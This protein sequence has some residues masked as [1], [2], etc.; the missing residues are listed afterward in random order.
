MPAEDGPLALEDAP[1]MTSRLE[2]KNVAKSFGEVHAL[3]GVDLSIQPGEIR[4]LLGHNGSGKSTLIKILAGLHRPDRHDA[5]FIDGQTFDL[6]SSSHA[7]DFGLRFVHQELGVVLDLSA[8]DNLALVTGYARSR[9]G[10]IAWR[11][12]RQ[13]TLQQL[14]RVGVSL[15]VDIPLSSA[16]RVERTAVALARALAGLET[17]QGML[18]LDEP[19][20]A[21]PPTEVRYLFEVIHEVRKSGTSVLYVSHRIDEVLAIADRVTVLR[22]GAV[23]AEDDVSRCSHRDLVKI[24]AEGQDH[25][26]Q[27]AREKTEVPPTTATQFQPGRRGLSVR[28]L[29]GRYLR[30]VALDVRPGEIVGVAG[31]VGSGR[32]E[33]PYAVVGARRERISG[34]VAIDGR[35]MDPPRI[36]EARD[37]GIAFVPADKFREG[38]IPQ[39]NVRENLT[40]SCLDQASRWGCLSRRQEAVLAQRLFS[41]IGVRGT[42]GDATI[43]SLSGGNQQKVLIVRAL[44]QHPR[45]LVL[46]E[47]TAGVDVGALGT[48]FTLLRDSAG[49][50]M[51]ILIAESDPYALVELCERVLVLRDGRVVEELAGEHLTVQG[52]VSA[53]E[54]MSLVATDG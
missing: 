4:A 17:G 11:R 26:Q 35:T 50:G 40:L 16:T 32:D 6:G 25:G 43:M 22:D 9:W 19:T 8:A 1:L 14:A 38:L 10:S 45:A 42:G 28:D 53:L 15:D 30:G 20:A 5:S 31:I 2:V 12:Q 23:V 29:R 41:D 27:V 21:L 47:P 44:A 46:A 24:I 39:F 54:S 52:I 18:V 34:T 3:R 7:A 49:K 33:L 51:A 13:I 36:A 48:L 37:L